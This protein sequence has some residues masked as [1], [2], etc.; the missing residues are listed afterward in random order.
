MNNLI[1]IYEGYRKKI[2]AYAYMLSNISW[3]SSTEAP[4]GSFASRS[5][6]IGVI[7]EEIHKLKTNEEFVESVNALC[8]RIEELNPILAHEVAEVKKSIDKTLKIPAYEYVRYQILLSTSQEDWIKAKMENDFSVFAP[9]LKQIVDFQRKYVKYLE[10]DKLKGYDVLLDDY[11]PG[12]DGAKYEEFFNLLKEKLVPFFKK[13]AKKGLNFDDSFNNLTY[14]YNK[15]KKFSKYLQTVFCFDS[16]RGLMKE[17]EHPFTLGADSTDV[18][19]TVKYHENDFTSSIFST[20]HELG[21]AI[22]EQQVN[23]KLDDTFS[24]G[25]ASTALHES[26]SRLYENHIGRSFAFWKKHFPKLKEIFPQ[27]LKGVSVESFY[28]LINRTNASFIR[29]DADEL[30]YPLH[31]ML[32]YDIEKGL[33]EGRYQVSD[34][35]EVWNDLFVKYFGLKVTDASKGVLQD[36]HWANGMFGYFPTYALGSAYASQIYE[37]MSSETNIDQVL[38]SDDTKVIN[39]WLKDKIHRHGSSLT[40]GKIYNYATGENFNPNYYINYLIR[41]YS[42]LYEIN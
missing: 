39:E 33:I 14:P 24:G 1:D 27:Q 2:K 15:Q 34:L 37:K 29:I 6:H 41:K 3:D 42:K 9:T 30:S 12:F 10:T 5:K 26:Q 35:E 38:A 11:E 8:N 28:K 25:G 32:R 23:P 21:H 17:S 19:F 4:K 20:I 31:I 18:R 16:N 22:Y 7:S 36:M 13:V 40:A